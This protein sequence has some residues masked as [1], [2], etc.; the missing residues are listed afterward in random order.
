MIFGVP[1]ASTH[2]PPG[3]MSTSKRGA[4]GSEDGVPLG[5]R[6]KASHVAGYDSNAA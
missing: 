4:F 3:N 2:G 5:R 1:G 6:L